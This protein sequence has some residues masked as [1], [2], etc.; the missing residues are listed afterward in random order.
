MTIT[1][2]KKFIIITISFL[3]TFPIINEILISNQNVNYDIID[4]NALKTA[5]IF[6]SF[7]IQWNYTWGGNNWDFGYGLAVDSEGNSYVTGR[8]DIGEDNYDIFIV[9]FNAAGVE[10]SYTWGGSGSDSG[11]EIAVDKEG[12]A[13]VVGDTQS[14]GALGYSDIVL[15]KFNSN[16]V[17]WNYTWG[18]NY[19]DDGRDLAIDS[20][21]DI[22]VTGNTQKSA[23]SYFDICL[24]KFTSTGPKWNRT[25]GGAYSEFGRSITLDTHGNKYIAGITESYGAGDFDICLLQ[26]NSEGTLEWNITWGGAEYESGTFMALDTA[27]NVYVSGGTKSFGG[28]EKDLCLMKINSNGDIL[29]NITWGGSED[30]GASDLFIDSSGNIYFH[31]ATVSYGKEDD[32]SCILQFDLEGNLLWNVSWGGGTFGSGTGLYADSQG[33]VIIAGT[34]YSQGPND[35]E[36][37][38][39]K[40]NIDYEIPG[41]E[42]FLFLILT[43][44]AIVV[45]TFGVALIIKKSS[46]PGSTRGVSTQHR[47]YTC[48]KCGFKTKKLAF[49]PLE[50][51]KCGGVVIQSI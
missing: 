23:T 21:G 14:F 46:I 1:K 47:K 42:F 33:D 18:G 6:K 25:W 45:V 17:V 38:I 10:W 44:G 39:V 8:T 32:N 41:N 37:F 27:G 22:Y 31:G 13:Y 30:D 11:Y 48:V 43:I 15:I 28:G 9:K 5:A 19:R 20:N 12:S 4:Q 36:V 2:R 50:C 51:P 29:W 34:K 24:V 26:F 49:Q 16:G 40:L 35:Y 3:F 7:S